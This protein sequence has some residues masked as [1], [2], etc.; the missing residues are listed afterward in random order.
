MNILKLINN[1]E[2]LKKLNKSLRIRK[3]IIKFR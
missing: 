3:M 1:Q 2:Q